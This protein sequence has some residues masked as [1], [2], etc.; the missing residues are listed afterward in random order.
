MLHLAQNSIGGETKVDRLNTHC[1]IKVQIIQEDRRQN[2]K[3]CVFWC[4][5]KGCSFFAYRA[6]YEEEM[7]HEPKRALWKL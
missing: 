2:R 3:F 1:P 4:E 6:G 7:R 5:Q